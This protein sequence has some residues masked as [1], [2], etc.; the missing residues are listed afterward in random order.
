[1]GTDY[2]A[3][4]DSYSPIDLLRVEDIPFYVNLAGDS[5]KHV[6]DLTCGTGRVAIPMAQAGLEVVGIDTSRKMLDLADERFRAA[7]K[8]QGSVQ[9]VHGDVMNLDLG[10]E[11]DLVVIPYNSFLLFLSVADQRIA[12]DRVFQHLKPGG[13]LA[14]DVFTPDLWRLTREDGQLYYR[15][16]VTNPESGK[17]YV[18]WE[19][20]SADNLTQMIASRYIIENL[21]IDGVVERRT[22][23]EVLFRYIYRYEMLHLLTLAGFADVDVYGDFNYGDLT[24]DSEVMVWVATKPIE[25]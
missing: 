19:Q 12:L 16:D 6:L 8:I 13:R 5:G 1:M 14:L 20:S 9:F 24:E 10:K 23:K 21:T 15:A 18:L 7:E 3:W 4:V 2:D 25:F 11:F 22:Y 17:R